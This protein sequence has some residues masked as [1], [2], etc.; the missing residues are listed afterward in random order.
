MSEAGLCLGSRQ[1]RLSG[2]QTFGEGVGASGVGAGNT[3]L[4]AASVTR[5]SLNGVEVVCPVSEVP[6][7]AKKQA[8]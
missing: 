7:Y 5:F 4:V 1:S 2:V 3:A 8:V 6:F